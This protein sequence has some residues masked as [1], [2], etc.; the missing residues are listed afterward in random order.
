[1]KCQ[2]CEQEIELLTKRMDGTIPLRPDQKA[3]EVFIQPKCR[4]ELNERKA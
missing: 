3:W 1:M 4:A 2:H